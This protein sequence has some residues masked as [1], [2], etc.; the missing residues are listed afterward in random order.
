M[1]LDSELGPASGKP[2]ESAG[3][4]FNDVLLSSLAIGCTAWYTI[5]MES[6]PWWR[7]VLLGIVLLLAVFTHVPRAVGMLLFVPM[8]LAVGRTGRVAFA[9]GVLLPLASL[10]LMC[11]LSVGLCG[12][13][14]LT[15]WKVAIPV[16]VGYNV[17]YWGAVFVC[18]A[19]MK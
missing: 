14:L 18:A 13:L 12:L 8:M 4:C 5:E 2:Q 7:G 16:L 9:F 6:V 10:V 3:S 15:S 17:L 1:S 11:A 19:L